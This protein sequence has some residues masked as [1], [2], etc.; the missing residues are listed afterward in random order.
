MKRLFKLL[1]T[2]LLFVALLQIWNGT[3]LSFWHDFNYFGTTS[4]F[5]A[6]LQL[7]WYDFNFFGTASTFLA[8]LQLFFGTAFSFWRGNCWELRGLTARMVW[9]SIVKEKA[10]TDSQCGFCG[11]VT[12][13]KP[14]NYSFALTS[15]SF[16]DFVRFVRRLFKIVFSRG[17][18]CMKLQ[19]LSTFCL[20][21]YC[22]VLYS[23][24]RQ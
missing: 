5:L 13:S 9:R 10:C 19:F 3:T 8:R 4:T 16:W 1:S 21:L 20:F 15:M 14:S 23:D 2:I 17:W 18:F 7:F 6:R 24:K 22:R 11:C 12:L